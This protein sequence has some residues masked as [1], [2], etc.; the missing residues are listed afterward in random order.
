MRP[1]ERISNVQVEHRRCY[2]KAPPMSRDQVSPAKPLM[3]AHSDRRA[4]ARARSWV[5]AAVTECGMK[6]TRRM[7]DAGIN[8][9]WLRLAIP[10][11]PHRR[12]D[13]R[14]QFLHGPEWPV[15]CCTRA[16]SLGRR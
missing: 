15:T 3:K 2:A 12:R 7:S 14:A 4:P 11:A 10:V 13:D 6:A 5:W 8:V 9:G 16:M 1:D